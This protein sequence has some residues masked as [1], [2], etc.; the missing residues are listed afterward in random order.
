MVVLKRIIATC[1]VLVWVITGNAQK[2]NSQIYKGNEFYL[3]KEFDK[4]IKSYDE[5]LSHES[6]NAVA[7][8]NLGAAHFKS[9]NM[10][11]AK[12]AFQQAISHS[13]DKKLKQR[14]WYNLGVT[15]I[16]EKEMEQGIEALKEAVK[17]DPTD[18]NARY[19]LQKALTSRQMP[20]PPPQQNKQ[21]KNQQNNKNKQSKLDKE[22]I[23]KYLKSLEE[24]EQNIRQRMNERSR[25]SANRPEKDW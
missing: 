2:S 21:Q 22:S 7:L 25:Q 16:K 12:T 9:G 20:P 14:A 4:A 8:Y 3:S 24:R 17:L 15:H 5:A 23:E 13:G 1:F 6:S 11:S 10:E 19:N 18:E